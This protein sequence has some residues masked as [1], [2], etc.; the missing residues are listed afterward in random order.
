MY[1]LVKLVPSLPDTRHYRVSTR[2]GLP[3][4]SILWQGEIAKSVV[5]RLSQCGSAHHCGNRFLPA[6]QVACCWDIEQWRNN[7]SLTSSDSLSVSCLV[8]TCYSVR[9]YVRF[10][11]L[12]MCEKNC[13]M[14]CLNRIVSKREKQHWVDDSIPYWNGWP[15]FICQSACSTTMLSILKVSVSEKE[16]VGWQSA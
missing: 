9:V 3:A 1:D 10:I 15:C 13:S 6:V 12:C 8:Y 11:V 5:Q 2:T 7:Q 16:V 14:L 4:V